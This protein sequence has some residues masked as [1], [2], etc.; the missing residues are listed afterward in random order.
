[1]ETV[2]ANPKF[3]R[4]KKRVEDNGCRVVQ[5]EVLAVVDRGD[6]SFCSMFL[7]TRLETPEGWI[8]SRCVVLR[9][10]SVV[11]V[12]VFECQDDGN[13]YTLLVD[14]Y[15]VADGSRFL[16][17]A[18]GSTAQDEPDLLAMACQEAREE[19]DIEIK[20]EEL[21]LLSRI[22]ITTNPSLTDDRDHYFAFCRTV[23]RQW[24]LQ[25]EG[26][27]SGCEDEHEH[28]RVRVFSLKEAFELTG[29]SIIIGL[30]LLKRFCESN[31]I[32]PLQE[33]L[34]HMR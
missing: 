23:S 1:M 10:D 22:P 11:I 27:K 31:P 32:V 20:P 17:F 8:I 14:Q 15:C 21:I 34:E 12:P 26:K 24:L 2:F 29:S 19:L 13:L 9:G 28:T 3:I 6:G 30:S 18:A 25:M 4:W 5:A 33:Y 16:G 7:D